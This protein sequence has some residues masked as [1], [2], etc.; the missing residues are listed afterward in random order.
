MREVWNG[1][2]SQDGYP[3]ERDSYARSIM[4]IC[5]PIKQQNGSKQRHMGR[6]ENVLLKGGCEFIVVVI[7]GDF[8]LVLV[9]F[10]CHV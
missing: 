6:T 1:G 4:W 9:R 8:V 7:I 10:Q 3:E 5:F 2:I